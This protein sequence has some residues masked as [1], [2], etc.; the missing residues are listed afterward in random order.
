MEKAD[1]DIASHARIRDPGPKGDP[2]LLSH[3]AA[4]AP[5][6]RFEKALLA[7]LLRLGRAFDHADLWNG[8][9]LSEGAGLDPEMLPRML[10]RIGFVVS[11]DRADVVADLTTPCLLRLS[12]G[13]FVLVADTRDKGDSF[14]LFDPEQDELVPIARSDLAAIN[15]KEV[16]RIAHAVDA[17]ATRHIGPRPKR[18]WF[19][20]HFAPLRARVLDVVLASAFANILAV[21]VSLF[22]LQVYDRVIPNQ[23][24]ATLWVLAGGAA[25]ALAMEFLLRVSRA[26]LI[27][28][29]AQE[30][31]I[32]TNRDLFERLINLRL[33]KQPIPAGSMVNAMREF[34]SV[35]E[36]F[37]VAAVGVVTDLPF[38]FVFLAVIYAIGGPVVL[39]VAL[40]AAVMI[41]LSLIFQRRIHALSRDMLGGTTTSLRLLNEASYGMETLRSHGFAPW[42]QQNWEEVVA[43]NAKHSSDHRR[44]SAG[45]SFAAAAIQMLTYICAI[46]AGVYLFFAGYL[47]VGGIIAI[48][49]LTSRTLAPVVQLSGVISR[50]QNTTAA[51][52]A[53]KVLAEAPQERDSART[54]VRRSRIKGKIQLSDI[55]TAY[56]QVE[57]PQLI[58]PQI[59][60]EPG[61]RW[62][63]LGE[64][65]SG[66]SLFLRVL[67]GLYEPIQGSYL[68]DGIEARQI[69]PSDLR[70]AIAFLPQ[71]PRLFKGTLR[72]NLMIG[73]GHF[74]D[75]R[76]YQALEFA[77]LDKAVSAV[78]RGLD[79]EI[80]D[81]GEGLS[82]GQR[83]AVGLARVHLQD[84]SLVLLDEP[85]AAMDSRAEAMFVARFAKWLDGRGA[86]ICTH[87]MAL[88]DAVDNVMI[89]SGGRL[90]AQG[91][92]AEILSRFTRT[93]GGQ[94]PA[95]AAQAGR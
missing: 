50:W 1:Q 78:T 42:F 17:L 88:M 65:G 7:Y 29:A 18:H 31:E 80:R 11:R 59:Q 9:P 19:W 85:T 12:D 51:L 91:P 64:N 93:D 48:S 28:Q 3:R 37:A 61:S 82:V 32:A 25:M 2:L 41:F 76:L 70:R 44:L 83:A 81:G 56:P 66:K 63:I 21:T 67:A 36:F 69:D 45:L 89:L 94:D 58:V 79:L 27:D 4:L 16:I 5:H 57:M 20:G 6:E 10:E 46:T 90:I 14:L 84:P 15:G 39:V 40:G 68:L 24:Q 54:Y 55:R 86:V 72:E 43:L 23:N 60:I 38:V 26:R 74:S 77:G 13:E 8:L 33:D 92:K 87:R 75:D 47:S 95:L 62:A 34:S 49:I 22:A 52:E 73:N 30:I 53:L 35:K 71:D